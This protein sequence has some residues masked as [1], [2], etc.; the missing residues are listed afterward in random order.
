MKYY[1]FTER[2]GVKLY[3]RR[4]RIFNKYSVS[5]TMLTPYI[6]KAKD[7]ENDKRVNNIFSKM[8]VGYAI[9]VN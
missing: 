1:I 8:G 3:V 4:Y 7:F 5:V 2:D 9:E 6:G